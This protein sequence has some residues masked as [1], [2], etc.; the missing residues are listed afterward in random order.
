VHDLA[1]LISICAHLRGRGAPGDGVVWAATAAV[2]GD[3][4]LDEARSALRERDD[5]EPLRVAAVAARGAGAV[6]R[7]LAAHAVR[8][9]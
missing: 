7:A 9:G 4:R 1:E 3:G 8:L 6:E 2:L 5:L